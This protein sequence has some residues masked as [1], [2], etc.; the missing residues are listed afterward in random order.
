MMNIN[1]AYRLTEK[2]Y[3]FF[4]VDDTLI[5]VKS[6]LNFQDFWYEKYQHDAGKDE[7][8]KDLRQQLHPDAC[9]KELNRMY[10]RHFAGRR[11]IDV[12]ARGEE[13]FNMMINKVSNFFHP[14]PLAELRAHQQQGREIVFVSGS[15]PALLRPIANYLQVKNILATT[16]EIEGGLYTGNILEPQ[17]IGEGKADAIRVFLH[18]MGSSAKNCFAYGD[19]LSDIPM[20]RAV[21][22]PTVVRGG[23]HLEAH[24]QQLG[25]RIISPTFG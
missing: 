23:R 18:A 1:N 17:T 25:W 5:A 8:Y 15:F 2:A 16:M 14:I 21:G 24:A 22:N 4:D 19:D 7:Y 3:V 20:L 9:W 6:M 11:V 13:W 12:R 10:Y